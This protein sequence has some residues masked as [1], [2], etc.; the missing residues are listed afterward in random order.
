M[1]K[2]ASSPH[3][4]KKYH[5]KQMENLFAKNTVDDNKNYLK[6]KTVIGPLRYAKDARNHSILDSLI[7]LSNLN[8][9]ALFLI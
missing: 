5:V 8:E 6:T 4:L 9:N 3:D 1:E 7:I 2:S